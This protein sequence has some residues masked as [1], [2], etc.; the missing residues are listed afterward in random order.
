M[1]LV[2]TL[3][4]A[5]QTVVALAHIAPPDSI[6]VERKGKKNLVLYKIEKGE[7]LFSITR[8]YRTTV[9]EVQKLNP[10]L[11]AGIKV[12]QV[13]KVPAL[14]A[15]AILASGP[16]TNSPAKEVSAKEAT[17]KETT[18]GTFSEKIHIVASG[19]TLY[20]IARQ[21]KVS[22]ANLMAWNQ[23]ASAGLTEGQQLSVSE[24]HQDAHTEPSYKYQ[25][26]TQ[27]IATAKLKAEPNPN[28]KIESKSEPKAAVSA[29]PKEA[30]A[31]AEPA[32]RQPT[33]SL[34]LRDGYVRH[35]VRT[36][37]TLYAIARTYNARVEQIKTDNK[38]AETGIHVGQVLEIQKGAPLDEKAVADAPAAPVAQ[39]VAEARGDE[40]DSAATKNTLPTVAGYERIVE[41]GIAELVDNDAGSRNYFCLHRTAPIGKILQVVN[42]LN[43]AKV[44]VRVIGKLPETGNNDKTA[45][46][47]SKKAFEALAAP[48][49]RFPVEISYPTNN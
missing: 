29:A 10:S 25:E 44:F 31:L 1:R 45:L 13:I 7:T 32:I 27:K 20:A 3:F 18:T 42:E 12:G 11:S 6:G 26:P 47:I 46:K 28:P 19:Q 15:D 8:K 14:S 48:D 2:L 21:Y 24:P 38:I 17:K 34:E 37:E 49:K 33:P 16:A 40:P 22:V 30:P 9:A 4:F 39:R 36:G 5:V 35:T 41:H 23:L 43:G